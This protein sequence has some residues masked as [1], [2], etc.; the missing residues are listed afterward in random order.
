[1]RLR[2]G[3]SNLSVFSF[4]GRQKGRGGPEGRGGESYLR[5]GSLPKKVTKVIKEMPKMTRATVAKDP[6]LKV[7]LPKPA[8]SFPRR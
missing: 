5:A 1:M 7:A 3:V 8:S 4:L 2:E 6:I